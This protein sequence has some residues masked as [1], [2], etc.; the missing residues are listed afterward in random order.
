LFVCLF[1]CLFVGVAN[2]S[3]IVNGSLEDTS[4]GS[5]YAI[6]VDF[7]EF[8]M[9][10]A[11]V[12]SF[13]VLSWE[14]NFDGTHTD[15][16]SSGD[17]FYIDSMLW[18][19]NDDGSLDIGDLITENDDSSGGFDGSI[20]GLDSYIST[21]LGA[22]D[23]ILAIGACCN[24]GVSDIIDGTQLSGLYGSL[25]GGVTRLNTFGGSNT[26]IDHG[27]YQVTFSGDLTVV[28]AQSVPEPASLALLSLG[29]IGIGFSRKKKNT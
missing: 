1:V 19:F 21:S 23:Y 18:L 7:W 17:H 4:E 8:T 15:V 14:D 2:A 12:A 26:A 10:S 25:D 11:G 20:S 27:D 16:N 29:L 28:N 9:N 5:N 3:V 13:D 6:T 24:F 22:G